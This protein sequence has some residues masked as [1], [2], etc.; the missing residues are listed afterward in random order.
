MVFCQDRLV[1]S[2]AGEL[3]SHGSGQGAERGTRQGGWSVSSQAPVVVCRSD[4][5]D[6]E[7][8]LISWLGTRYEGGKERE[9]EGYRGIE[10]GI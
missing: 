10:G 1:G 6:V 8:V 4:G 5:N 7:R 3:A 2:C 9:R